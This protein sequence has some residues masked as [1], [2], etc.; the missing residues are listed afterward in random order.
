MSNLSELKHKRVFVSGAA[1]V[2]GKKLVSILHSYGAVVLACDKK[3]RPKEWPPEVQY[4]M[5]DLNY[6][7]GFEVRNFNPDI[8]VHLAAAF[9]RSEESAEFWNEGFDHNVRL[10]HHILDLMKDINS[11]KRIV[12]ASSYLVY[13]PNLYMTTTGDPRSD[14][15]LDE[16]AA[17]SPRNLT[18]YAKLMHEAE[19]DF[20][21]RHS[22]TGFSSV[23]AR[24]FRGYGPGSRDVISRWVRAGLAGNQID[25]YQPEGTFD[26]VYADDTAEGLARLAASNYAGVI[27]L[28]TGK[29]KQI[30]DVLNCLKN[31]FPNLDIRYSEFSVPL[32]NSCADTSLLKKV[33]DWV[34]QISIEEAIPEIISYETTEIEQ[35]ENIAVLISSAASK[36]PLF[37][38]F[39]NVGRSFG[40]G[41]I[42]FAGDNNVHSLTHF[43]TPNFWEMPKTEEANFEKILEWLKQNKIR[44]II[45]TRDGELAFFASHFE[46]FVKNRISVLG[47]SVATINICLDKL[48]FFQT[49]KNS[50]P[51]IPTCTSLD[52]DVLGRGPYV[53]KERFGSGSMSVIVNVSKSEATSHAKTLTN[54]IFQPFIQGDEF[55]VDAFVR[56]DGVLHGSVIRQRLMVMH[57]ESQVTKTIFDNQISELTRNVAKHLNLRGH[58]VLQL[59]KNSE[60]IHLIECNPRIGGASTL[61]FAAGLNT[62]MWS[63]LEAL[64][65]DLSNYPFVPVTD[66]IQLVRTALDTIFDSRL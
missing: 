34:P 10:S 64:G 51:A 3:P 39:L 15:R 24:I 30:N 56:K 16:R 55:S 53:V 8:Y 23:C 38:T 31:H 54:P 4:R 62:P 6:L 46:D 63:I 61:S 42:I 29:P 33:L 11:L 43:V 47:S 50:H 7:Q 44:L 12:F 65:D 52:E 35:P 20:C 45:P 58:F 25:V 17:I 48:D 19:L 66:S 41:S 1:G 9:E 21:Q 57:G 13:D 22:A 26:Y 18:G 32:E 27:N 14:P 28:G 5:G 40:P 59:I 60:G 37:N 2:I 49:L 36:V